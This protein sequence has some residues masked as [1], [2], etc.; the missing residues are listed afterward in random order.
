MTEGGSPWPDTFDSSCLRCCSLRYAA[1]K[2]SS[3][4]QAD[5]TLEAN[6]LVDNTPEVSTRAVNIRNRVASIRLGS[7]LRGN[8][9]PDSIHR[10]SIRSNPR[11]ACRVGGPAIKVPTPI[12]TA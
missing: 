2:L 7:I 10:V 11:S 12:A 8:I 4:F 9:L 3:P 5:S 6:I 1:L